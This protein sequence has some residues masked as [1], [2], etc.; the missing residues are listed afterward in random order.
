M[1]VLGGAPVGKDG[2]RPWFTCWTGLEVA[3][4]ELGLVGDDGLEGLAEVDVEVAGVVGL[5]LAPGRGARVAR[6]VCSGGVTVSWSQTQNRI[7]I[8]TFF[9]ARPGR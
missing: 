6:A 7:G 2:E 8:A 1:R 9:A 5:D 4:Q 3:G